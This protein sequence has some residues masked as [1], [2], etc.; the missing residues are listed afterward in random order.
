MLRAIAASRLGFSPK[1]RKNGNTGL[2]KLGKHRE[3]LTG[4]ILECRPTKLPSIAV[5]FHSE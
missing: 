5:A 3:Q 4:M 2:A 1:R